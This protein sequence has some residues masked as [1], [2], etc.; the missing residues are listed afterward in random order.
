LGSRITAY[1]F[2]HLG[3]GAFYFTLVP[4]TFLLVAVFLLKRLTAKAHA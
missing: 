3:G 2:E 4:M 1:F